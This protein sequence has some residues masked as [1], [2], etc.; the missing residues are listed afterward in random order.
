M[1]DSDCGLVHKPISIKEVM[2]I[3]KATAAVDKEWNKLQ[4]MPA[5]DFER[6]KPEAKV[7]RLIIK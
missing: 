7:V 4:N 6:V 2:K 1:S 5:W 3:P